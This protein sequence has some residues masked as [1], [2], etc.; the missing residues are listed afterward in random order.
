MSR[1]IIIAIL[2][3]FA[4]GFFIIL[5]IVTLLQSRVFVRQSEFRQ[6]QRSELVIQ[7]ADDRSFATIFMSC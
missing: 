5:T 6:C 2:F 3:G 7:T 1:S 4:I